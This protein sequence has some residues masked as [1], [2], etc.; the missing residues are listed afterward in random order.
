MEFKNEHG[1]V[2]NHHHLEVQEQIDAQRFIP[3]DAVVLELGARYGT[4]SCVISKK[5]TNPYN[6]VAVEPDE[7]VWAAL[8]NNMAHNGCT[9]HIL[10][11]VISRRPL[12]L[13]EK[14]A[15]YGYAATTIPVEKSTIANYTLEEVEAR[16]N[17]KFDTLVA[18]CEGFLESFFDENPVLY[19]Q[20]RLVLF[21]RDYEHKCNYGKIM[22][23]LR[24][25]GFT[26]VQ[27]GFHEVWRK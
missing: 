8:D 13:T 15:W 21:E 11:G 24:D 1:A 25:A 4:V 7:R 12:E 5:L 19:D 23:R 18:D 27:A 16:Y 20:L 6:L 26:Q 10:K 14:D 3:S 17:L 22:N 9:C 2:V